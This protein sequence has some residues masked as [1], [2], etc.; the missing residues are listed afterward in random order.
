MNIIPEWAPHVHPLLVH[1]P[2]ALLIT[3]AVLDLFAL[4][5]KHE[6]L[7]FAA[8]LVYVLGALG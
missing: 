7:R 8:V 2:I 5:L 6:R 3:A 4:L 1:F